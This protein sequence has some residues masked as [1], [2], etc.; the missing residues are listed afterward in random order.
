MFSCLYSYLR[1]QR[2]NKLARKDA[3][4]AKKIKYK[5]DYETK[6]NT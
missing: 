3:K 4:L 6:F 5:N 2:E 1:N